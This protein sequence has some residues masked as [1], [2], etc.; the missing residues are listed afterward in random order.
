MLQE[1]IPLSPREQFYYARELFYNKDYEHAIQEFNTFLISKKGWIEN[2]I[3][4]CLNLAKCYYELHDETNM[5]HSLFR[6]FEY[7]SP[8]A[9]V[10]CEIGKYF[11]QY[12]NY[13]IA[14]FWYETA[15]TCT[16]NEKSGAFIV[17]DCYRYIPYMQ[18]CVCYDKLGNTEKAIEYNNKAG[19]I[20]PNDKAYLY[21]KKY[22]EAQDSL[23]TP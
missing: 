7:D 21:N 20:K 19:G 17:I 10:C 23:D 1:G 22:F 11:F 13:T 6:S 8:R 15:T 16:M 18:L 9:E 4:T 12:Q 3:E 5:L 2:N 14:K